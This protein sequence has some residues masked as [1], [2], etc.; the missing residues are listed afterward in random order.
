MATIDYKEKY[1]QAMERARQ[2]IEKP[3]LEDS[4]GIV[5]HIFPELAESEDE[6]MVKFIQIQLFN[7]KKTITENYELDAK[8]TKAI[9]WLEKQ[10]KTSP[11]LSNSLDTGKVEQKTAWSEEDQEIWEEISNLLWEGFK[12]TYTKFSWDEIKGWIKP[13]IESFKVR[14]QSQSYWKPTDEQMEYLAKAI[15]TLGDEGDCKTASIL[16]Y[17]RVELKKLRGE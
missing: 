2:F 3:Y 12:K 8:L 10:G 17:L 9:D 13:K 15:T 6:K 5:R 1:E 7:I 11:I 4:A 16:N 14:A